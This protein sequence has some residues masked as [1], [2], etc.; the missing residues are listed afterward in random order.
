MG[1]EKSDDP[2]DQKSMETTEEA[3]DSMP[4]SAQLKRKVKKFT[5]GEVLRESKG[6]FIISLKKLHRHRA[7]SENLFL[8]RPSQSPLSNDPTKNWWSLK[9]LEF[10]SLK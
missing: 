1:T 3:K 6:E 7:P 8:R 4:E 9:G 10:D 5:V 2:G